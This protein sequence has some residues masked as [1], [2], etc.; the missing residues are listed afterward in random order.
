MKNKSLLVYSIALCLLCSCSVAQENTDTRFLL[1]TFCTVTA[2]ANAKTVSGA[3]DVCEDLEKKL[4]RTQKA[5][6]ISAIN[7]AGIFKPSDDTKTVIEKG[8]YYSALS[9]G[10]FDITVA[11]LTSLW[12]FKNAVIPSRDEIAEALKN[13]DYQSIEPAGNE[14]K[15]GGKQLDL[16][17]IAKGYIADRVCEYLKANDVK[18]G[19]VNLGGNIV[20]FGD[21]YKIG[22]KKPFSENDIIISLMLR[23][24]SIS[25]SGVYERCFTE[26]GK[27]YHHIL[28][29]ETGYPA[30]TDLYSAS[31]ICE[32]AVD[33]D[34]LSTVCMLLGK[35]KAAKLIE[36]TDNCEAVFIDKDMK[37][38]Y[39]SGIKESGG[40]LIIK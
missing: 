14:I 20:V 35:E 22:L 11:P 4:S 36:Q 24:T 27:L 28:N 26:N 29:A 13:V 38:T 30:E 34:A 8:L 32:N 6:E 7:E 40:N 2:A 19:I 9:N 17:A 21:E 31:V 10:L 12:D 1:D 33:G 16:G 18:K 5:S 39:T 3:L 23:D 37:L 25:T 15:T